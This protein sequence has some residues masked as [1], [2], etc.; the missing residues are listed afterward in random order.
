MRRWVCS[1]CPES[2]RMRRCLPLASTFSTVWPTIGLAVAVASVTS[3]PASH[4]CKVEAVRK[5]TSPSGTV[6]DQP[7]RC[8]DETGRLQDRCKAVVVTLHAEPAEPTTG[9]QATQG[10]DG[11][12][13]P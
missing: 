3:R 1:T 8:R 4:R 11:R 2:K 5:R 10:G 12:V 13:L 6:P 9:D 7:P